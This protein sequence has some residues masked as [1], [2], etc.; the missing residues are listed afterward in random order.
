MSL[1][2][3]N[4]CST[5]KWFHEPETCI[6]FKSSDNQ[7]SVP[8]ATPQNGSHIYLAHYW[9]FLSNHWPP[10]TN[11]S[12][13][14]TNFAKEQVHLT[15]AKKLYANTHVCH[16]YLQLQILTKHF[17]GK[18][19]EGGCKMDAMS[20]PR[21]IELDHPSSL[22]LRIM[23]DRSEIRLIQPGYAHI[24]RSIQGLVIGKS[25]TKTVH[26]FGNQS[27]TAP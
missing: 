9:N 8:N 5:L 4:T 20:A 7:N 17:V 11:L 26:H 14:I 27:E 15:P 6:F 24:F 10:N 12:S 21:R 19:F 3:R 13:A 25:Q 1:H 22:S 16:L 2:P 23:D 18:C